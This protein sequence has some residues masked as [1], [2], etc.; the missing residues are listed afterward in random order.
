LK[1]M[2]ACNAVVDPLT[3]ITNV[4]NHLG[5]G[6]LPPEVRRVWAGGVMNG[7]IKP[8]GD[9]RPI[10]AGEVLRRLVSKCMCAVHQDTAKKLFAGIQFGVAQ[11]CG[12]ERVVHISRRIFQEHK[13]DPNFVK[14]KVDLS[15]AFNRVSR[16]RLLEAVHKHSLSYT[17]GWNGVMLQILT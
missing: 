13:D 3:S 4:V 8:N 5:A 16:A 17:I 6:K 2:L 7:L 1:D 14:V 12:T 9:V 15:N 11:K 10:A